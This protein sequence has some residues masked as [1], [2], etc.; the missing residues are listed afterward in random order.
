[1]ANMAFCTAEIAVEMKPPFGVK[2]KADSYLRMQQWLVL[3][4]FYHFQQRYTTDFGGNKNI[5]ISYF[6]LNT[7]IILQHDIY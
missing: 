4:S 5:N 3:Q 2:N 7:L 6:S 1:M